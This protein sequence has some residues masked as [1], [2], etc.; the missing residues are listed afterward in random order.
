MFK[1]VIGALALAAAIPAAAGDRQ[2]VRY[3]D[4]NLAS[5]VGIQILE[6]RI[7]AAARDVCGKRA[8]RTNL[9]DFTAAHQCMAEA[10]ARA[11][12]QVAALATSPARG[13]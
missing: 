11:G 2:V 7:D 5:P 6:R 12:R 1:T 13:G 8:G 4:L 10:K 3:D 9:S